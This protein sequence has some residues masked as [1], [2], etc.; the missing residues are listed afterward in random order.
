MKKV[1][2]ITSLLFLFLVAV[3]PQNAVQA[4]STYS[5]TVT[6]SGKDYKIN[7]VDNAIVVNIDDL[8]KQYNLKETDKV[9]KITIETPNGAK[10]LTGM[11]AGALLLPDTAIPVVGNK[12]ELVVAELLGELDSQ[13][14]GVALSTVRE[15][16][17]P[18][19]NK[20]MGQA[21][22]DFGTKKENLTLVLSATNL[23]NV[24]KGTPV[25]VDSFSLT[26]NGKVLNATK[27]G[28]NKFNINLAGF[29]I[30]DLLESI[31][32]TSNTATTVSIF[33]RDSAFYSDVTD[34]KFA[35]HVA[36]LDRAKVTNWA[37]NLGITVPNEAV[38]PVFMVNTVL[39]GSGITTL[40]GVVADDNGNQSPFSVTISQTGWVQIDGAWYY[41]LKTGEKAV[42]WNNIGGTWYFFNTKTGAMQTGWVSDGGKWYFL[43]ESGA[44]QTGW[45]KV[46]GKWYFLNKSG[47]MQT[48]WIK[49]GGQSYFLNKSGEMVTG[50]LKE[51]KSNYILRTSGAWLTGNAWVKDGN[52]WYYLTNNSATLGWIKSGKNWY[53]LNPTTGKMVTGWTSVN[54]VWYFMSQNGAMV[55]GW[56]KVGGEW[57]Y[58]KASGAMA[59]GWVKV[60]NKW[61][62]LYSNGKM[63]HDTVIDGYKLDSNGAWIK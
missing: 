44:M 7:S 16:L 43:S 62:Y 3:L 59:T 19:N 52:D 58:L 21:E 41:I 18:V 60:S 24:S 61:Y 53:Y 6:I 42:G 15:F 10:T 20:V 50:L 35:N 14:D 48:G 2:A 22:V 13:Q 49:D 57:Y 11:G 47:A 39:T 33:S 54:G 45:V 55:T 28:K 5:A 27:T 9:E 17:Y 1:L 37:A 26:A 25:N 63:A 8:E 12:V 30:E 36:T 34:V 32:L 38:L 40:N 31:K 56:A 46:D 23:L 51:G 29:G 4:A